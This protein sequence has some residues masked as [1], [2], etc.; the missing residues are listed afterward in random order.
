MLE[1]EGLSTAY[2]RVQVLWDISLNVNEGEFVALIGSNG[3]GKT[4][5][6]KTITGVM[7]PTSGTVSFMGKR[8]DTLSPNAIADLGLSHIPESRRLF[9][10]MSVR[11]NLEMGAYPEAVLERAAKDHGAR[12]RAVSSAEGKSQPIG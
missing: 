1:I 2:G 3:A 5:L 4:T 7:R 8:I 12:L 6:L 11:E 9:V 10:D